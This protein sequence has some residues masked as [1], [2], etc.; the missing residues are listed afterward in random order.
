MIEI[1]KKDLG[2]LCQAL[3]DDGL[4]RQLLNCYLGV[5]KKNPKQPKNPKTLFPSLL[6]CGKMF[7]KRNISRMERPGDSVEWDQACTY[8]SGRTR[9]SYDSQDN[10]GWKG[11]WELM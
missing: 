3:E 9:F 2:E 11:P 1:I 4:G 6:L 7:G 5:F 8:V 10:S